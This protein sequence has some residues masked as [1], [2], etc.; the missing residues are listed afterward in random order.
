M[1]AHP[2]DPTKLR[3]AEQ[4]L[5]AGTRRGY[6]RA[7]MSPALTR[8]LAASLLALGALSCRKSSS[9]D[10]GVS[11]EF[12]NESYLADRLSTACDGGS[13]PG[14]KAYEATPGK[15]KIA[16]MTARAQGSREGGGFAGWRAARNNPDAPKSIEEAELVGC[17]ELAGNGLGG[18]YGMAEKGVAWVVRARD[19]VEIGRFP[20]EVSGSGGDSDRE[21]AR[22]ALFAAF[23]AGTPPP[24]T[25][26][27]AEAAPAGSGAA[28]LKRPR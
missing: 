21:A 12:A 16:V 23:V 20:V 11:Q 15:H 13:F 3:A 19:G 25:S 26:A 5:T 1:D 14:A 4:R 24:A 9:L 17:V 10:G 6:V 18:S 7:A 22:V 28:R 2:T 27:S 8:T